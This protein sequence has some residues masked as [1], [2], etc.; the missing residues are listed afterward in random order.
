MSKPISHSISN[1]RKLTM[2]I[3]VDGLDWAKLIIESEPTNN[4]DLKIQVLDT[5][6]ETINSLDNDDLPKILHVDSH[7]TQ[8]YNVVT[9]IGGVG[10]SDDCF[11]VMTNEFLLYQHISG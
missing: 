8:L 3:P 1:G 7:G 11:A 2:L 4:D 9:G 10:Q 6:M 5:A